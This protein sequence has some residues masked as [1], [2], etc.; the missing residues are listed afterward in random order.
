M[1]PL[2]T[3]RVFELFDRLRELSRD[4]RARSLDENLSLTQ[5]EREG[6]RSLLDHDSPT[7]EF[8]GRPSELV[9]VNLLRPLADERLPEMIG[10]YRVL[11]V[12][13]RGG[14]GTVFL[15]E[16][17]RPRRLVA[18]KVMRSFFTESERRR[19]EFEAQ[20]LARLSHPGIARV[21]ELG[22]TDDGTE[23][24][25]IAMEYIDGP[26]IDEFVRTR[27][28]A[29]GEIIELIRG[30]CAAVSHAHQNGVLHR[31][32]SSRNILVDA[33]GRVKV[34]DFGLACHVDRH[35][36][37][38][39]TMQGHVLGTLR[40]MSPEALAGGNAGG[41]TCG[42]NAGVDTR[43]DVYALGLIAFELLTG[44]HP[45]LAGSESLGETVR[46]QLEAPALPPSSL[47]RT[48]RGDADAVLLKGIERDPSRRYQSALE[49]AADLDRLVRNLPVQARFPGL[50]Y[51]AR[52]FAGRHRTGVAATAIVLVV[53]GVGAANSALTLRR[54]AQA[55][56][57]TL[58]A[59][60][61]VVSRVLSPIA[62]KIGTM[63]ER[64]ELLEFIQRDVELMAKRSRDDPRAQ[65]VLASYLVS[66]G[67]VQ[68]DE[69]L[70][71]E[72]HAAF[73]RAT[74]AY[75]RLWDNTGHD[76]G[77][78]HEYSLAMVKLGDAETKLGRHTV[79]LEWFRS[80]LELDQALV[81]SH[82]TDVKLL[83][84]LFWSYFRFATV[85]PE[86]QRE[87]VHRCLVR[88]AQTAEGMM[89]VA[90]HEWRSLEATARVQNY[91]ALT[92]FA[93]GKPRE[94]IS[95]ARQSVSA[96]S[97]LVALDHDAW[98]HQ[99]M[100]A[101]ACSNAIRL[102][103]Q[104][105]DLA[106]AASYEEIG[107]AAVRRLSEHDGDA[108]FEAGYLAPFAFSRAVLARTQGNLDLTDHL[109]SD[110]EALLH[111]VMRSGLT[112]AKTAQALAGSL[113]DHATL[114][115]EMGHRE[116]LATVLESIESLCASMRADFPHVAEAQDT[117]R[118][119]EEMVARL[120]RDER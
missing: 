93:D 108:E 103:V 94:A 8:L 34:L 28:P 67:D 9:T 48:L 49:F 119:C 72:S 22:M 101:M 59:L 116:K 19:L 64:K 17:A 25:F 104:L 114:L 53:G 36:N 3:S 31:D 92:S 18:V 14:F 20:S 81:K 73:T 12:L 23:R 41:G 95:H 56:A 90:P 96:A 84:N 82:P 110:H 88:A 21:Y 85:L 105:G 35:E 113:R 75:R 24:P 45:Y 42:G 55:Q 6:V 74:S 39:I 44:R 63:Q 54:E 79:G 83:S 27:H 86:S 43:S 38:A 5:A 30:L 69:Y 71:V 2:E 98:L 80:A 32:L 89:R 91:L 77:V 15:C 61:A 65:R 51:R 100:L 13:G 60:D 115:V 109:F 87:E 66:L 106:E 52:K 10:P 112:D 47:N 117:V 46:L 70:Y 118:S 16:Q 11:R 120:R 29:L 62:P 111:R 76:A 102:S 107:L 99:G 7:R 58:N 33:D 1:R 40:F 97:R 68:R 57:A 4:E 78:G 26:P 37:S 50:A